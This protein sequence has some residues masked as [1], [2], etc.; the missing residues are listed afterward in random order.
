MYVGLPGG[1]IQ[2]VTHVWDPDA[3]PDGDWVLDSV[4][5]LDRAEI[6]TRDGTLK[7]KYTDAWFS[8]QENRRIQVFVIP[9]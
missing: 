1:V 7:K 3:G 5:N 8:P 9:E 2:V 4:D 6:L